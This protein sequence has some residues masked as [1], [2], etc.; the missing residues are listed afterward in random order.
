MKAIKRICPYSEH[1]EYIF[2]ETSPYT[3]ENNRNLAN[4]LIALA[5][6]IQ[7]SDYEIAQITVDLNTECAVNCYTITAYFNELHKVERRVV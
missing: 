1:G 3:A 2:T 5:K 4:E 6:H 7:E